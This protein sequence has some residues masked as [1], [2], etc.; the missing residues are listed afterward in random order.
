MCPVI[1]EQQTWTPGAGAVV[2]DFELAKRPLHAITMQ[3]DG[4]GD[5]G[6]ATVGHMLTQGGTIVN[7][8]DAR[9]DVTPKWSATELNEY[10]ETFTGKNTPFQDG[11]AANDVLALVPLILPMGRPNRNAGFPLEILDP[12][13]GYNP[14]GTPFLHIEVPADA[15]SI[16]NR[17]LKIVTYYADTPFQYDKRWTP[18]TSQTVSTTGLTDWI[19]GDRGLWLEWLMFETTSYN[20]TLGTDVPSV[21]DIELERG[22]KDVLF[23]GAVPNILG[24]FLDDDVHADD[25]YKYMNLSQAPFNDFRNC[26]NLT[27][28]TKVRIKGGVANAVT[29]AFSVLNGTD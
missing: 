13:V 26:I 10:Y 17:H 25:D 11:T 27:S 4:L 2:K 1:K 22:G 9:G 8:K 19:V 28:E 24:S 3:W 23:D 15:N 12:L 7:L 14:K 5:S 29:M 6:V 16:D 18:W 20:D 21:I